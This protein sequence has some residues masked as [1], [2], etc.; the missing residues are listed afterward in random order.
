VDVLH[1][2]LKTSA[3]HVCVSGGMVHTTSCSAYPSLKWYPDKGGVAEN[4]KKVAA[5]RMIS[6]RRLNCASRFALY[7]FLQ[8]KKSST[9]MMKL[10]SSQRCGICHEQHNNAVSAGSCIGKR[11]FC[12]EMCLLQWARTK[13][14]C[15][16]CRAAFNTIVTPHGY[17][18]ARQ[19]TASALR[20]LYIHSASEPE[21]P[22]ALLQLH[23]SWAE[24]MDDVVAVLNGLPR[25]AAVAL[26]RKLRVG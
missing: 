24:H 18:L 14:T 23:M 15:P 20:S 19:V 12:C 1:G 22:P 26:L 5:G 16:F 11:H 13:S 7:H 6:M 3:E 21:A 17:E 9:Q 8:R 2:A 25:Q 4:F 10:R